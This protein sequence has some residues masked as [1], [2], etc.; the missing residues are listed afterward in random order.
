MAPVYANLNANVKA[1]VNHTRL[2]S[3]VAMHA[4]RRYK[5]QHLLD[6]RY[7]G[8]RELFLK[9]SGL[10]KGR[11]SQ[12]LDPELPFGDVAARNLEERLHLDPGYFDAMDAQTVA[13]AVQF[14]A[15]PQHL[16]AQ[17]LELVSMLGG[18]SA[19]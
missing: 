5:L 1:A 18:K 10:S 14:D 6:H 7:K 17:W 16:K 12:L 13:F 19:T 4:L 3:A 2:G 9:D 8:S 15:L 11:L